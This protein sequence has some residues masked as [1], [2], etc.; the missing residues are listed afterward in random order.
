AML[1]SGSTA[2]LAPTKPILSFGFTSFIACAT[3]TSLAKDGVEVCI[4]TSSYSL[5]SGRTSSRV[6]PAGGASI[7]RLPGISAAGWASQVGYQNDR[8]SRRAWYRAPAPPSKPSYD[9]GWR[10]SVRSPGAR[11]GTGGTPLAGHQG[12]GPARA[13]APQREQ[14]EP[15]VREL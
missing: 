11:S 7:N 15:G 14:P 8:I 12:R 3:L 13:Q 2:T 4:T 9:G 1:C 10:N 6:V 5:A